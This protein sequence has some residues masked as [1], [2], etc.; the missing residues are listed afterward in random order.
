[1][2]SGT[3]LREDDC[4]LKPAGDRSVV[5]PARAEPK[6][7]MTS[8]KACKT[9]HRGWPAKP[10]TSQRSEV[11]RRTPRAPA[12]Q[13]VRGLQGPPGK[14]KDKEKARARAPRVH[15]ALLLIVL[16]RSANRANGNRPRPAVSWRDSLQNL[17]RYGISG[18][19]KKTRANGLT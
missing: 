10:T 7:C 17:E 1:M 6:T 13:C 3:M 12:R 2:V 15:L 14:I 8:C 16:I 5:R 11:A 9:P 19:I 4:T 18:D